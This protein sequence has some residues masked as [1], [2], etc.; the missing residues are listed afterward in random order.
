MQ[1]V[2]RPL[3][4]LFSFPQ[5]TAGVSD[6]LQ[7]QNTYS[8]TGYPALVVFF[9]KS[10]NSI[11][12]TAAPATLSSDTNQ[13]PEHRFQ[14]IILSIKLSNSLQRPKPY[15]GIT[16]PVTWSLLHIG[17]ARIVTTSLSGS[18][19]QSESNP[20]PGPRPVS[21]LNSLSIPAPVPNSGQSQPLL[22]LALLLALASVSVP[23]PIPASALA[24]ICFDPL[25]PTLP[26]YFSS[27]LPSHSL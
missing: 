20:A 10:I 26:F 9:L 8:C 4:L 27:F 23:D 2:H 12:L 7:V 14:Y 13:I 15:K 17:L 11:P 1:E 5:S 19:N 6:I 25:Y 16:L 18:L 21:P 3:S 24:E 22:S